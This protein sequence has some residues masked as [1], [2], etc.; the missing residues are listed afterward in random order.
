MSDQVKR[1]IVDI[2]NERGEIRQYE[3]VASRVARFRQDHPD[4]FIIS[5]VVNIN[6]SV[7]LVRTEIGWYCE[8]ANKDLC[9]VILATG[10]AEEYRASSEINA[11]AAPENAE[12]SAIGRALAALGY[13]SH[14]SY[15]SAQEIQNAIYRRHGTRRVPEDDARP[16]ALILLQEAAEKG[17]A[18]LERAW[19]V[20]LSETDRQACQRDVAAL[21][22]RAKEVDHERENR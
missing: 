21:K 1:E 8:N 10:L 12:T 9:P 13:L 15:S 2:E 17:W 4:W 7:C 11:I 22:R 19:K 18:E 3:T 14:E 5:K 16:G 6:D 20:D